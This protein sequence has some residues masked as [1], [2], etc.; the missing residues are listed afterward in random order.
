MA[1]LIFLTHQPAV[2]AEKCAADRGAWMYAP[3]D[4]GVDDPA[5]CIENLLS[6]YPGDGVQWMEYGTQ[7]SKALVAHT[8]VFFEVAARHPDQFNKWLRD[9]DDN[10]FSTLVDHESVEAEIQHA[11]LDK[12]KELMIKALLKYPS[13]APHQDLVSKTLEAVRRAAVTDS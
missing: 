9:L 3:C 12:L 4:R 6:P 7:L 8:A 10:T 11:Y 13:G 5:G 1:L 2:C